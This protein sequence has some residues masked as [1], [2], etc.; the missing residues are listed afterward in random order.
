MKGE[1]TVGGGGQ[2]PVDGGLVLKIL[3]LERTSGI[4]VGRYSLLAGS[5]GSEI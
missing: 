5:P 3:P 1:G 4:G 2:R